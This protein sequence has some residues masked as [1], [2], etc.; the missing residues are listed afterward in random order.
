MRAFSIF[1][2]AHE[3]RVRCDSEPNRIDQ[4]SRDRATTSR[5]TRR[6]R[7]A[8]AHR[9][10][11]LAV[12]GALCCALLSAH[13]RSRGASH[14]VA[15]VIGWGYWFTGGTRILQDARPPR[16]PHADLL[17]SM[18]SASTPTALAP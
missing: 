8:N 4:H 13:L 1:V 17:D 2:S 5:A 15:L 9:R 6:R 11:I 18:H 10:R 12:G 16:R 14:Y 3:Q 7:S